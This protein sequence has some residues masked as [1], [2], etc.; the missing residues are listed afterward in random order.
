MLDGTAPY[1]ELWDHKGPVLYGLNALGLAIPLPDL[2]GLWALRAALLS[3]ALICGT[4][5]L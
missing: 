5:S 3:A 1:V 2:W 4:T